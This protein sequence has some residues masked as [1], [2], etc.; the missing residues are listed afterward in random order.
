MDITLYHAPGACS[1]ATYISLA[2]AG[3][4]F[5]VK[6]ISLKNNDQSSPEFAAL[7]PKKKVP[8]LVVDGKGLSENAAMQTWIAEAFPD[9]NLF[10][11]DSW[12]QKQALSYMSWFGSGMHPHITRHYKPPKF[13]E[14]TDAHTDLKAKAKAMFMEQMQLVDNEL[15]G[16]TFFFDHY[17]ACDSYF[18]WIYERALQEG[19]DLSGFKQCTAHNELLRKR[20]S[21]QKVLAHTG[22]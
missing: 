3:A 17:T 11:S 9:A 20:A 4:D 13:T 19:F 21:V 16:K 18:F 15:D 6:I 1:M 8:Y 7:N 5:T 22:A 12:D 2:E 14:V 10:P